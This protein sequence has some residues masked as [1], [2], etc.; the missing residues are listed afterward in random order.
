[1]GLLT[2]VLKVDG[3]RSFK[4]DHF[5]FG[6][7]NLYPEGTKRIVKKYFLFPR[8][9]NEVK[10]EGSWIVE[11]EAS[12]EINSGSD[13]RNHYNSWKNIKAIESYNPV[14]AS[15]LIASSA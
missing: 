5:L 10:V 4:G 3:E 9:I 2:K 7:I 8:K 15:K 12:V 13:G 11:Q 6:E 14:V 1:M